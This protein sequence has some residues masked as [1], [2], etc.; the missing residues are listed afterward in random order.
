MFCYRP[1][2][3]LNLSSNDLKK[4]STNST[5]GGWRQVSGGWVSVVTVCDN[6]R[7][8]PIAAASPSVPQS[9]EP[10]STPRPT[11]TVTPSPTPSRTPRPTNTP[12]NS[13][14]PTSTPIPPT[15][16]PTPTA[17]YNTTL[18][19]SG[20][21]PAGSS[22][23]TFASLDGYSLSYSE[24]SDTGGTPLN[25]LIY[26]GGSAPEN[27]VAMI[28]I[29]SAFLGVNFRLTTDLGVSYEEVFS[30]SETEIYF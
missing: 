23:L 28:T 16:T 10:T 1:N 6:P 17:S 19:I 26:V 30:N 24:P 21:E 2:L 5:C 14:A 12:T 25:I 15:A 18:T 3:I 4:C 9:T 22:G 20:E 29:T 7:L 8:F 11:S 27:Q 13:P